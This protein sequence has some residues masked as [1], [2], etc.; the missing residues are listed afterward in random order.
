MN[1][2]NAF[3]TILRLLGP[4]VILCLK[5]NFYCIENQFDSMEGELFPLINAVRYWPCRRQ[6]GDV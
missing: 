3:Q 1:I 4:I 2:S 5:N 6:W